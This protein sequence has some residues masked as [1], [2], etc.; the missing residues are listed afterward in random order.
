M[1]TLKILT[2]LAFAVLCN[3]QLMASGGDGDENVNSSILSLPL[4]LSQ[5]MTCPEFIHYQGVP[6]GILVKFHVENDF[7]VTLEEISCENEWLKQHVQ[8]ELST[9][10]LFVDK[11]NVG[12]SYSFKLKYQ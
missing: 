7:S 2:L 8:K 3:S 10:K 12:K 11:E 5:K 1:K 4:Q 6:V 9:L